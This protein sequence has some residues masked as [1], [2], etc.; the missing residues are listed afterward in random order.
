MSAINKNT[1]VGKV[2]AFKAPNDTI[3]ENR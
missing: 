2:G 1:T 3:H